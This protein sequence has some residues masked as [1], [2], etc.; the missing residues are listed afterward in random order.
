MIFLLSCFLF[1]LSS[2]K[3]LYAIKNDNNDDGFDYIFDP[4]QY[5]EH[6]EEKEPTNN[7]YSNNQV[8][9]NKP[10]ENKINKLK[11]ISTTKQ[12]NTVANN[13]IE[14]SNDNYNIKDYNFIAVGDWYC[15]EETKKTINNIL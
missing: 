6:D 5:I 15:N 12:S 1:Y 7:D 9:E 4:G 11:D 8:N 13:L 2:F 14:K 10:S 3:S